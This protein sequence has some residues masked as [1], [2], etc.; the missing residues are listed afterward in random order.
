MWCSDPFLNSLKSFGYSVVRLPKTNIRPLQVLTK[1]GKDLERLGEITTLLVQGPAATL[2]TVKENQQAAN[3]S[4][5]R[6]GD[7]SFG[8][9][10][11]ILGSVIGAMGGSK[12]GLDAQYKQA[13]TV[14]FE[15]TDV[16]EDSV[17][18]LKLDQY[19]AGADIHP[20]SR[21]A[22]ELLE[23]DE[24]YVTTATLKTKKLSV[25]AKQSN[26]DSLQVD[27]PVI[28]QVVG[29]NVK[30]SAG[31]QATSKVTY[32]GNMPLVF[33]F[34]AV[35]LFYDRSQ[36]TRIEPLKPG[37]GMKALE[38]SPKDGSTRLVVESPF[39]RLSGE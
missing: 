2:P 4:G 9:G 39:A 7:L 17:E 30:V 35:R 21:Y 19:L 36:Y 26:G 27:V 3:I 29:G 1:R 31:T 34:Q 5:Q 11:S 20:M 23:V 38:R 6:T 18:V 22:A 10:L 32:E 15:F 37:A 28:Q 24:I 12:L 33:G 13:K 25:G 8:V 14:V 16:L